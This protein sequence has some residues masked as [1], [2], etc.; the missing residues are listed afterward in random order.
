MGQRRLRPLSRCETCGLALGGRRFT[1]QI[2][3]GRLDLCRDCMRDTISRLDA[4]AERQLSELECSWTLPFSTIGPEGP[5][6]E[7]V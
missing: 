1:V 3:M 6:L 7:E 4:E 2:G 5:E